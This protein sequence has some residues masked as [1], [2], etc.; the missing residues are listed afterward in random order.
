MFYN[1]LLY[2]LVVIFIFSTASV[3][4]APTLPGWIMV[5]LS[6]GLL[7][8]LSRLA[9]RQY[10]R[11]L[12]LATRYFRAEKRLSI[13]AVLLF[14]VAVYGLDLKYYLQPFSAGGRLPVLTDGAGLGCFFL[15]MAVIWVQARP[16]YEQVFGRSYTATGFVLHNVKANLPI[17]LPWLLLSLLFDLLA[18]VPWTGLQ[19]VLTSQWGELLLFAFV[20]ILLVLVFPP[21]VRW[22]WGCRPL[23]AGNLRIHLQSFCRRQHF[24][25]R[26]LL[27][28]LFE[29]RVLTAAVM[30]LIPGLRYLLLTPAL[31]DALDMEE[32]E[33]VVGHEI[34]HVKK[35]HLLLYALLFL[36]FSF[37]GARLAPLLPP[38]LLGSDWF[39][40]VVVRF[41]WA[42][43]EALTWLT[44]FVLLAL[45]LLF[46]R[47]VFGFFMRNFERQADLYVF[48]VM[49]TSWPL[50]SAFEKIAV[51]SGNIRNEKSWHHFGIGERITWLR[52]C[53]EDRSLVRRHDWKVYSSLLVYILVVCVVTVSLSRVDADKL[54]AGAEMRYAEAVLQNRAAQEP[55]NSSI[56]Q[57]LGDVLVRRNMEKKAIA[58]YSRALEIDG[59]NAEV[60]NNL[61]WLLLTARDP[62]LRDPVRALTL[63]RAAAALRQEGY[64]LDT[65]ATALWANR[66]IQEA[67][68]TE[69]RA[70]RL[71]PAN[72]A[73]YARQIRKFRQ[74]TWGVDRK[75]S[76]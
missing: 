40:H 47:F 62:A 23:P 11:T 32:L 64:I 50:I 27:W 73:F 20:L 21:L 75:V 69:R 53:E 19:Q 66:L 8:G 30:G 10:R 43:D 5:L 51:L 25:A 74:T 49:G 68:D 34:G 48:R 58:A 16:A 42:P 72:R 37:M 46:F 60:N 9:A 36:G 38:L 63:A 56:L 18:Q 33:S 76:P 57:V 12:G 1:N 39:Y 2:Y 31:L 71:D 17:I 61:A 67:I 55:G 15:L 54:A 14:G 52:K 4:Q 24:S 26:I 65:L 45:M 70:I 13:L 44:G 28:P 3:P 35:L 6:M 22:L 41:H 29:G 59:A 7:L